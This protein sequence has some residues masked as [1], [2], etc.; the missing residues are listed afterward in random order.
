VAVNKSTILQNAQRYTAKGQIDK[1]IEEW[2]KLIA[3]TPNDGNIYNTI[4]DLYLKK[5]AV[6]EAVAIYFK[7]ANAFHEAGFALKTIAVYK[8]VIKLAPERLDACLKLAEL[9]AERGLISNAIEDYLTIARQY[10]KE[11][12]ALNALNVYRKIADLDP[13]NTQIRLKVAELCIKEGLK[14]EAVEEYLKAAEALQSQSQSKEAEEIYRRVL[15]VDPKNQK[16]EAGI[17]AVRGEVPV[18]EET[19]TLGQVD[20]LLSAN[21]F[22]EAERALLDAIKKSPK[23]EYRQKLANLLLKQGDT[24]RAFQE[25]ESLVKYWHEKKGFETSE[26]ILEDFL[27]ANPD[28][29]PALVLLSTGYELSGQKGLE[30][31]TYEKL[32]N[33]CLHR[34]DKL[35]AKRFYQRL[36]EL[37][38][39][40]KLVKKL[41]PEFEEREVPASEEIRTEK[42]EPEKP[43][44]QIIHMDP[45]Q[46]QGHLTEA[47]VYL[48]Y[49]L[50]NKAVEQLEAVLASDPENP[51]AHTQLKEIYKSEGKV[52]KAVEECMALAEIYKKAGDTGQRQ[53]MLDEVL[54]LDP[55]NQV[56]QAEQAGTEPLEVGVSEL[57][58][59]ASAS[60][61]VSRP[62]DVS[63]SPKADE[64]ADDLMTEADF[65]IQQGLLDEAK[66]IYRK[67]LTLQPENSQAQVKL[68][69]IATEEELNKEIESI[70]IDAS[71]NESVLQADR[72]QPVESPTA[73]NE[74]PVQE[75]IAPPPTPSFVEEEGF[76]DLSQILKEDLEEKSEEPQREKGEVGPENE[77]EKIFQ[78]FQKGVQDQFGEEDYETH[79]NLGIAYKEMGLINEAIGEFQL[80]IRGTERFIDSCSMLATCYKIKGMYRP[81]IDQ[82]V[83]ALEDPRCGAQGAQWLRYELGLLY[84]KDGKPERAYEQLLEIYRTDR[85]F[86]DV[87]TRLEA[88]K[89]E[90]SSTATPSFMTEKSLPGAMVEQ[91]SSSTSRSDINSKA[92]SKKKGRVSYL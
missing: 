81:A 52:S 7:A 11:G 30:L 75:P 73:P 61:E 32:I 85:N 54:K 51:A 5:N 47:E 64:T 33:L 88:L 1:A 6:N 80:S 92:A 29:I 9:N 72:E 67:V 53:A 77:F 66:K 57:I 24:E 17:A 89:A 15:Q 84:E 78:E 68:A 62:P 79:Y 13:N 38:P 35:E 87:K 76:I 90:L 26:K 22:A 83:K 28:H 63:P 59:S 39:R 45:E 21:Q 31:E 48:K 86:R 20:A 34:G 2:Q 71:V 4:G 91:G 40:H 25:F 10:T 18:R 44:T 49:G 60:M 14:S 46:V 70:S 12:D 65:Y 56:V 41:A 37:D 27:N 74:P 58:E 43:K 19:N 50:T 55:S 69:E 23:L 36:A 82:L 16:A 42:H 3:E 8:K